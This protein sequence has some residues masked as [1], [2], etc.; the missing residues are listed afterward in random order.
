MLS[1]RGPALM[2]PRWP[3]GVPLQSSLERDVRRRA[4]G[5]VETPAPV[6]QRHEQ[7]A[8]RVTDQLKTAGP[9]TGAGRGGC[10]ACAGGLGAGLALGSATKQGST[11]KAGQRVDSGRL[12]ASHLCSAVEERSAGHV[13]SSDEIE[14]GT[15]YFGRQAGEGAA[16]AGGR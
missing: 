3:P 7:S 15:A 11:T 1:V 12:R 2:R 10:Q 5:H 6:S 16:A 4:W 13:C 14:L 9:S 8:C